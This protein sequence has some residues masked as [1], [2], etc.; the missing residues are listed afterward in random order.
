MSQEIRHQRGEGSGKDT[1]GDWVPGWNKV[2]RGVEQCIGPTTFLVDDTSE[3]T[4]IILP[5]RTR[6]SCESLDTS[7]RRVL[8]PVG[9]TLITG[10]KRQ[11]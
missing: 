7:E 9:I 11:E 8:K 2:T 1:Y 4:V 10:L 3:Y 6:L 5:W